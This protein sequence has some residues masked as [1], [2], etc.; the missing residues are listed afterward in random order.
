MCVAFFI[1]SIKVD[2]ISYGNQEDIA[3]IEKQ[4]DSESISNQVRVDA[5]S[6]EN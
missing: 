2:D 4:V 3:S 6:Y 1:A 5:A